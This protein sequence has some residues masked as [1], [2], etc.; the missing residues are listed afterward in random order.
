MDIKF[1]RAIEF[2][3]GIAKQVSNSIRRIIARNPSSF[4]FHGT[5]TYIIGKGKVAIIDPGPNIPEH[6]DSIMNETKNEKIT[7]IFITHTHIDHSPATKIL[8]KI[9]NAITYGYGSHPRINSANADTDEE[10]ADYSF[11]PDLIL[12]DMEIIKG[13]NWSL[14]AIHTPG[15]CSN[16]LCYKLLNENSIFSG[17][18]IMGWSTTVIS[19]PNGNMYDYLNSLKKIIKLDPITLWPTHGSPVTN[20]K[21]F[22]KDLIKHRLERE[23]DIIKNLNEGDKSIEELVK[24]IY[25][26]IDKSLYKAAEKSVMAHLI[27][28][29]EKN[30]IKQINLSKNRTIYKVI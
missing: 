20:P 23:N 12:K 3:Y 7:D 30:I 1:N 13:N 4:T 11:K 14:Q 26:N 10:G 24:R 18:H 25:I 22:I 16:H 9:T 29:M 2:E 28:L 19:P 5:G 27:L 21:E 6:I 8:K 17:D 15:H